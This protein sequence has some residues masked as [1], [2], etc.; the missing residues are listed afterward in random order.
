[1]RHVRPAGF[2]RSDQR[3]RKRK[4]QSYKSQVRSWPKNQGRPAMFSAF[5][6]GRFVAGN[7]PSLLV[8]NITRFNCF[9]IHV[10]LPGKMK[11]Y[12]HPQKI[13][14][15]Q[16]KWKQP[17]CLLLGILKNNVSSKKHLQ[18]LNVKCS[19][20]EVEAEGRYIHWLGH[21]RSIENSWATSWQIGL[22]M[23]LIVPK[24]KKYGYGRW[25]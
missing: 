13:L 19:S 2:P 23:L 24:R 14:L 7:G 21:S 4:R 10:T 9:V 20:S 8:A 16:I 18:S 5:K 25:I 11:Q 1:M 22:V 17:S 15:I 3:K 12:Q 6:L